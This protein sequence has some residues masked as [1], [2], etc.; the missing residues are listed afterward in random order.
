[1]K[2]ASGKYVSWYKWNRKNSY[3]SKQLSVGPS[4]PVAI[5]L[6]HVFNLY[7]S[8]S[9]YHSTLLLQTWR[10]PQEGKFPC[11]MSHI[12][13]GSRGQA[14]NHFSFFIFYFILAKSLT[15]IAYCLDSC[16]FFLPN[17]KYHLFQILNSFL[18]SLL[19]HWSLWL[20]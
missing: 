13:A 2:A 17:L 16:A 15:W 7:K 12:Q 20:Y 10:L 19:F 18:D 3:N 8:V 5:C 4:V 6:I 9:R 1:M 14:L 11:V